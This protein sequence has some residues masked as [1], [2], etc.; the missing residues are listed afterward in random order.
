MF[1]RHCER[2][3]CML[4]NVTTASKQTSHV[5][6]K[7]QIASTEAKQ[8]KQQQQQQKTQDPC[9]VLALI[10]AV[11]LCV[12]CGSLLE[13][14]DKMDIELHTQRR[15]NKLTGNRG[16]FF[17]FFLHCSDFCKWFL[18]YTDFDQNVQKKKT[19]DCTS[20]PIG[21]WQLLSPGQ[22]WLTY[23]H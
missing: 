6:K 15:P 20:Y 3:F 14:K 1:V 7:T 8:E 19:V 17:S 10:C 23:R 13:V 2:K 12:F 16:K 18:V 11:C 4:K 22:S 21:N 5:K 9:L